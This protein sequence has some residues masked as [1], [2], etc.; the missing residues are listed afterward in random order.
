MNLNASAN[1]YLRVLVDVT[2]PRSDAKLTHFGS[3]FDDR[4]ID[5]SQNCH[6]HCRQFVHLFSQGAYAKHQRTTAF[7]SI[8]MIRAHAQCR[9][10]PYQRLQLGGKQAATHIQCPILG[11]VKRNCLHHFGHQRNVFV[12]FGKQ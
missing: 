4:L 2:T 1:I 10:L 5:L 8:V 6:L 11:F 12:H 9:R 7:Q 3:V